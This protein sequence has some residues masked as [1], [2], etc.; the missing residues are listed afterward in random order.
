M[1]CAAQ[2]A[3]DRLRDARNEIE[4]A[5]RAPGAFPAVSRQAL[6]AVL[7]DVAAAGRL[8]RKIAEGHD[9]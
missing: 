3:I 6:E 1:S 8:I 9:D 4:L 7:D 2:R 5:L